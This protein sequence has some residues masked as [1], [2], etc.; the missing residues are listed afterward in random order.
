MSYVVLEIKDPPRIQRDFLKKP[1][2]TTKNPKIRSAAKRGFVHRTSE[3]LSCAV[4]KLLDVWAHWICASD[5][6]KGRGEGTFQMSWKI[7]NEFF[8]FF[9]RIW[10]GVSLGFLRKS[11]FLLLL[12]VG[13]NFQKKQFDSPIPLPSNYPW[14]L[15]AI[16]ETTR[17]HLAMGAA[18]GFRPAKRAPPQ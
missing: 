18:S 10:W 9:G 3:R 8:N 16:L 7:A 1:P 15:L 12:L 14:S 2:R 5:D 4:R 17:N 11:W 13:L 6:S